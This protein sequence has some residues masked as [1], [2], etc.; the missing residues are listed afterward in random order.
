MILYI[1]P[2][3]Y[4]QEYFNMDLVSLNK[5]IKFKKKFKI[6]WYIKNIFLF[7]EFIQT[8]NLDFKH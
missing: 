3:M 6:S 5:M 4:Q 7:L 1:F 8:R 2:D